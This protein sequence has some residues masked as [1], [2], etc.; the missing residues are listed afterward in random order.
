M[1]D[2]KKSIEQGFG[3]GGLY[4]ILKQLQEGMLPVS[5]K[6]YYVSKK[7]NNTDG[8]SWKTA[9]T[10]IATAIATSNTYV[11]LTENVGRRNRMYIDGGGGTNNR[12][13][14]TLTVFP[15][16]C[17]VIG[18]G[19]IGGWGMPVILYDSMDITTTVFG[20]HIYNLCFYNGDNSVPVLKISSTNNGIEFHNCTFRNAGT[21]ATIGLE[22][23]TSSLGFKVNNCKVIGNP[24][25]ITGIQISGGCSFGEITNNFINATTTGILIA[26]AVGSTDYQLLIKDNVICRSDSNS[27][28]Q[29]AK[30]IDSQDIHGLHHAMI[31]HNY[32]SATDAIHYVDESG[33][34]NRLYYQVIGN[35]IVEGT[36]AT[37][38]TVIVDG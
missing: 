37:M 29:L 6:S 33:M 38:E 18:V 1:L 13:E 5:G 35:Y 36:T 4:D 21:G 10:T 9:F 8:L 17:D 12:W 15:N 20:C 31:V 16:H 11:A 22:F 32:I 30:G 3:K 26:D 27:D 28:A 25:P 23:R 2:I 19:G 14:E 24:L 34:V 7:G